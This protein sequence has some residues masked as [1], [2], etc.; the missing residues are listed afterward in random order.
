MM[1]QQLTLPVDLAGDVAKIHKIRGGVGIGSKA[2]TVDLQCCTACNAGPCW[3]DPRNTCVCMCVCVC[4][5]GGGY[6]SASV[7]RRS[8]SFKRAPSDIGRS[9]PS[10][11]T[12][13]AIDMAYAE[14]VQQQQAKITVPA[15]RKSPYS[16][17]S[18]LPVRYQRNSVLIKVTALE[19]SRYYTMVMLL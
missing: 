12:T 3:S 13:V 8:C 2:T 9:S 6:S 19:Y 5:G 16:A 1:Q 17:P 11:P 7:Q 15:S 14:N 10:H 18:W 4:V